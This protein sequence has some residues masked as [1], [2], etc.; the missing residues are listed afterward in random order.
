ME[1][2]MKI[3][4]TKNLSIRLERKKPKIMKKELPLS[5]ILM[6]LGVFVVQARQIS[7]SIHG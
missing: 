6:S 2:S 4:R 3:L 7:I 1:K 5:T